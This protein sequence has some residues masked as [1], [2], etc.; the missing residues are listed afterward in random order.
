MVESNER[1]YSLDLLRIISMLMIVVLHL[2]SHGGIL[3]TNS[4]TELA[5]IMIVRC[6]C[7][8]SV[9]IFVLISGY[10]LCTQKFRL[11]KLISLVFEVWFY[12]WLIYLL[13][14][15]T[16]NVS[17]SIT[18]IKSVMFPISYKE[19]WF[20]TAY[21][22][23]YVLM[24]VLNVTIQHLNKKQH[25]IVVMLLLIL[26]IGWHDFIP[27][28]NPLGM[29]NGYSATWFLVL[30]FVAAYI[31]SHEFKIK[32]P[33]IIYVSSVI[34]MFLIWFLLHILSQRI[35]VLHEY[36]IEDYY[37]NYCSI[38]NF[39]ASVSLF[40]FFVGIKIRKFKK[41]IR[42]ITPLTFGIY[43]IHDNIRL[44]ELLWPSVLNAFQT[45]LIL[46]ATFAVLTIFCICIVIDY[47]RSK[48]FQVLF[49]KNI[50]KRLDEVIE[51]KIL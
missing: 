23:M 4:T 9:N 49:S 31:R 37:Y 5:I 7:I 10:F 43:L 16:G 19:Y 38:L 50:W 11:S 40:L 27:F 41:T 14:Y 21:V 13:L 42:F 15:F 6:F 22:G 47:F 28:S 48:V 36:G 39:V 3:E 35:A 12:T 8:V 25:C 32:C 29:S 1:N 30:Y 17:F 44:R 33:L 20:V 18:D 51:K 34:C 24:P 26:S 2:I 45:S 46:R